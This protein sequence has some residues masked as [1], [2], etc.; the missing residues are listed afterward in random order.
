MA[1][2]PQTRSQALKSGA[3][4]SR[5]KSSTRLRRKKSKYWVKPSSEP[6]GPFGGGP[7]YE[8]AKLRGSDGATWKIRAVLGLDGLYVLVEKRLPKQDPAIGW[9]SCYF[10]QDARYR[11][12]NGPKGTYST[13][14]TPEPA[15][16][17]R[18]PSTEPLPERARKPR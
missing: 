15:G 11:V 8:V 17:K 12:Y 18:K 7:D 2:S 16:T 6:F 3:S 10:P 4:A 9:L 5:K 1:F 14:L 13:T